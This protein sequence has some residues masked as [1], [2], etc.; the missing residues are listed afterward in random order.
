MSLRSI[1]YRFTHTSGLLIDSVRAAA[2]AVASAAASAAASKAS[3]RGDTIA[4]AW[5]P[6]KAGR[7]EAAT[8][9][10]RNHARYCG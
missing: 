4:A 10:D 7:D 2:S 6:I 5:S 9:R 1:L 8:G 3:A